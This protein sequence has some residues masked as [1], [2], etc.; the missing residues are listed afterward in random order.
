MSILAIDIGNTNIVLGVL[1]KEKI[2]VSCTLGTDRNKTADEYAVLFRNLLEIRHIAVEDLEGAILSSVV[3]AL[4]EPIREA[5]DH[6]TGKRCLMVGPGLKNGLKIRIDDPAQLGSDCVAV[7]VAAAAE[8][9]MPALIFDMGTATTLS[10]LNEKGEY[11]GGMLM[12]GVR[13]G[14]E[15]LAEQTSQLPQICL[16]KEPHALIGTNSNDCMVN[17]VLYGNAAMLD[18]IVDRLRAEQGEE[19]T[20]LATGSVA[21]QIVTHCKENVIYDADLLLKGLRRIYYKNRR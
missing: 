1:E 13:I 6:I 14:L 15:A 4:K 19:F 8:Y 17:G 10:V 5:V 12:P 7:A 9:P 18:G 3:P 20:I 16:D 11:L 21:A 2:L